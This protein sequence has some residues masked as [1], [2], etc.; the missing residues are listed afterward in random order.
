MIVGT[1]GHI[2][3]GKT[4]LV[5]ALTGVDTDRLKEEKARG[6]SI[7]LGYAYVPL[8]KKPGRDAASLP[9]DD[10]LGF[11]DVPGHERLVH[12]MVA[13]ASGIDFAL[14]VV[15]A[16]DGVMPQTREHLAILQLLGVVR[17][18]VALTKADRVD[19]ARMAQVQTEI[20]AVLAATTLRD[21]PI[22]PLDARQA[23][24]ARVAALRDH[25]HAAAAM[26][27][28]RHDD[29]LF[30]LAVDRVFTLPGHGTMVTGTVISGQVKTGD[31]LALM[32]SGTPV[33]VR[34]IHAQNRP[35]ESG[36]AGQRCALN[37]AGVATTDIARG[38]WIADPRLLAPTQRIDVRL[39]LLDDA[40]VRLSQWSPVHVHIGTAHS[41]TNVVP[42]D[43]DTVEAGQTAR[44]QFV[45]AA[46]VCAVPGDRFIVRNAQATR[47]IGGGV[48]LDPFAPSRKRRSPQRQ[49]YLAS[50][51]QM[52]ADGNVASLLRH[53]PHG[54]RSSELMR[55]TGAPRE[56]LALPADAIVVDC[57]L[58]GGDHV[59]I[60][61]SHWQALRERVVTALR[62]FHLH[63]PDE[64]G[65]DSAR[66]RRIAAPDLNDALWRALIG[67]L[68][69]ER[70][71]LRNAAWLHLPGHAATLSESDEALAQKLLALVAAGGFD[72][73][74]VRELAH[75][76]H[77]T[78]DRVR[79][80]LNN[81]VRQG[82][83]FQV[84]R[85]LFYGEQQVRALADLVRTL[86]DEAGGVE[87]AR[88]RDTTG[89]GRKRAI[90]ILEFFDR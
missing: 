60:L 77:E 79:R 51:E 5:H 69:H 24:D 75:A 90:Q 40:G 73:P 48:V 53:A 15:A 23:G 66:L 4:T 54:V 30:R 1:A 76:I 62:E 11:V 37:L 20:A 49:A 56:R 65:P 31:A 80:V 8:D 89:V 34:S 3:H 87:A 36:R 71:V 61:R 2:D 29:G 32:P 85:D 28:L 59:M 33:R 70:S 47:T 14:L 58:D 57:A 17:G 10:V 38:D 41:I 26:L 13:G 9:V 86:A 45:F 72:P 82:R 88:F 44:V 64:P 16:D 21:A 18:A 68:T 12:T 55:L 25:L 78:E 84:V 27:P 63:S 67:E 52:L 83:L 22:F 81:L 43:A 7:E 6:I 35:A 46:P 42:L 19:A 74:W 50:M 39:Q